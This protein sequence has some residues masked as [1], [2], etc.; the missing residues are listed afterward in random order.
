MP[1]APGTSSHVVIGRNM[2]TR[3]NEELV[4]R[5]CLESENSMNAKSGSWI[6]RLAA[7][8]VATSALVAG[9]AAAQPMLETGLGGPNNYGTSCLS[10][11]DDGSSVAIPLEPAFGA[12]G[13]NFFG[14]THRTMYVNTNGNIT[15]SGP[16][17]TFT[18]DPF[19]L[20]RT[21]PTPMIAPYW[22]DID[23]RAVAGAAP[24]CHPS[25]D[26]NDWGLG[27]CRVVP[28][29]VNGVYWQLQPGR[30]VITWDQVGYYNCHDDLEM[31]FQLILTRPPDCSA[32]G[33]F[34]VEFRFTQCEWNTGDASNGTGGFSTMMS[35]TCRRDSDCYDS[36][37]ESFVCEI[38][39]GASV[40][41]CFEGVPAQAGFDA[42]NGTDFVQ[43]P[44]SRTSTVHTTM[45]T[46]SNVGMPGVW[47][48]QI[49]A[50][51]VICPGAGVVCDTGMP[52]VCAEGRQQCV[53]GGTMCRPVVTSS[54]ERCD[55]L[56][57]N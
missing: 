26:G 31:T 37:D 12:D 30:A 44:G 1:F 29:D 36:F 56:D 33:D 42:G 18:P 48:F 45:C 52:G 53:G 23:T 15:F 5:D 46:G 17:S 55:G 49:R 9:T 41:R 3:Y 40:G 7:S 10:Y 21:M 50:G 32:P 35:S 39:A 43:I 16:V 6:G 8:A 54:P 2:P 24:G 11:N 38:P 20:T 4:R 13:L 51:S 25:T 28:G 14:M 47:K 22:T 34:D 57:N 27:A 19:P